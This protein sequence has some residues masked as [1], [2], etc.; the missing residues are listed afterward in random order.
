MLDQ[1]YALKYSFPHS[2]VHIIDNSAGEAATAPAVADDP[3]LFATIVVT[4]TPIG[5]DNKV[6][7]INRS[8]I[9]NVAYGI[10]NITTSDIKRFGQTITYPTKMIAQGA[11]LRFMR[12]TPEGSTFAF[13]CILVQWKVEDGTLRIRYKST[14]QVPDNYTLSECENTD[15]LRKYLISYY[16]NAQNNE[17]KDDG[18]NQAAFMVNT[19]AGRGKAYNNMTVAVN[20][21]SQTK[22]PLNIRYVFSTID[23][24]NNHT[25]E[26]FSASLV[27]THPV[28]TYGAIDSV[29]TQI[30]RRVEGSSVII[31]YINEEAIQKIYDIYMQ[32]LK[33]MIENGGEESTIRLNNVYKSLTVDTFDIIN[34]R[35]IYDGSA[36]SSMLPFLSIDKKNPDIPSLSEGFRVYGASDEAPFI[37]DATIEV[38]NT[39]VPTIID[40][41]TSNTVGLDSEDTTVP[42]VGSIYLTRVG[43]SDDNPRL[44][45]VTSVN[46][47]SGAVSYITITELVPD[48]ETVALKIERYF[49]TVDDIGTWLEKKD[50]N[51]ANKHLVAYTDGSN[52]KIAKYAYAGTSWTG[53]EIQCIYNAIK[54]SS[55]SVGNIIGLD[56]NTAVNRKG[57]MVLMNGTDVATVDASTGLATVTKIVVNGYNHTADNAERITV[58]EFT[59][60]DSDDTVEDY[61]IRRVGT[62]SDIAVTNTAVGTS[63]DVIP[64][65]ADG[66]S[67]ASDIEDDM[68]VKA[69]TTY[70][71]AAHTKFYKTVGESDVAASEAKTTGAYT[72]AD[73]RK[74]VYVEDDGDVVGIYIVA[75][76]HTVTTVEAD[77]AAGNLTKVD[78][79][80]EAF[81]KAGN[82][83]EATPTL[84]SSKSIYRY[85]VSGTMG[86]IYRIAYNNAMVIPYNYY[87]DEL[88]INFDSVS[89][90][91]RLENGS[92]GFFDEDLNSIEF[93][94]RYSELMVKAFNG[95]LDPRIKSPNRCPAKYLF[96]GGWNTVYGQNITPNMLDTYSAADLITA[97]SVFTEEEKDEV[98]F[99]TTDISSL[100]RGIDIDV[101]RAMYDLTEYRNYQGI[102]E[103]MRPIGPGSG[104]SLHLD[105]GYVGDTAV[106]LVNQSFLDR[107][108][109]PN[110]S[111]DI[112]GFVSSADGIEYTYTAR[113]AWNLIA[114]CKQ[115]GVNKPFTGERSAITRD[116][117]VSYFPDIDTIDWDLRENYYGC[118]GNTWIADPN[119][120]L[121]RQSQR[122]LY[123]EADT[124][125]LVQESNMRTLS[126]LIYLL[127]NKINS[128]LL[129]YNDD[130]VL[131]TLS[132]EVN[133]MFSG[134]VGNLVSDLDISFRRDKNTDGGDIV[135]CE[136]S[137]TFRGLILRVPI[138]VNVNRRAE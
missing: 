93:K 129:E 109:N 44:N 102:P 134:W 85:T 90:G 80:F 126:Q 136:V 118:G 58:A 138:I 61:T 132:D 43:S 16:G 13:N 125:D 66:V 35:Y 111:W 32:L 86:S 135:V 26:Q 64:Y 27:N 84:D 127:Q 30:A 75:K 97:S 107:F 12:V 31:P 7:S 21:T 113:L 52:F 78:T 67:E 82:L 123:R 131:K 49:S 95:T 116:E 72:D 69:G 76:A 14:T 4:P 29:N 63:Y 46:Q 121:V 36:G 83:T 53:T 56:D 38:K 20:S 6:I 18:W 99:G 106:A 33:D 73:I 40:R 5:L 115:L 70:I 130:G 94:F 122:T 89:G 114:M 65:I 100:P 103:N 8:D 92:T 68:E 3:S 34:G 74:V 133:N 124:S 117:Y 112:G 48:D 42:C 9:L 59:D 96:D 81:T 17:D 54:W 87:T 91:V 23:T 37:D 137:V 55:L 77:V 119:G 28:G 1:K 98:L 15:R 120:R 11:P 41:L 2:V 19:S 47:Y 24:T 104:M 25:V 128:Y 62:P 105:S 22:K 45:L 57:C 79:F 60:G 39:I 50:P 71:N 10:N 51:H 101:K 108:S 88:G 110:V